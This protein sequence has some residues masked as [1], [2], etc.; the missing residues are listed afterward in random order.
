MNRGFYKIERQSILDEPVVLYAPNFVLN[1][2]YE[3]RIE[4]YNTYSYPTD[5]W[6]YFDSEVNAYDFFGLDL[7]E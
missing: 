3:L 2:D 4:H 6:Y 7:P 1:K 5:G